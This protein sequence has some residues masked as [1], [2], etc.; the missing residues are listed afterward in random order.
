MVE[1]VL[2]EH[3]VAGSI[4]VLPTIEGRTQE[5]RRMRE[6][7]ETRRRRIRM[8]PDKGLTTPKGEFESSL[9]EMVRQNFP[10][11]PGR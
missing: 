9:V 11:L 8:Y 3:Q 5:E 1:R 4:P 7:E 6:D 2:W 10:K